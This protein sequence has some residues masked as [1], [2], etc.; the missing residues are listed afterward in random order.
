MTKKDLAGTYVCSNCG[1]IT[2]WDG[3]WYSNKYG[4]APIIMRDDTE[5]IEATLRGAR[6]VNHCSG[7]RGLNYPQRANRNL[8]WVEAR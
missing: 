5:I 8:N 1:Y 6:L 4:I 2:L 3:K 7:C